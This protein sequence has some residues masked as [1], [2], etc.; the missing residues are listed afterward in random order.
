M[1]SIG[2]MQPYFFPYIGYYQLVNAVDTM[3]FYDDVQFIK[4]GW[5]NRNKILINNSA[6][7]ITVPC[8]SASQN[9]LINEIDHNLEK[10]VETKLLRK[11]ELAYTKATYFDR[12]FPIIEDVFRNKGEKISDISI[13]SIVS[14][15]KYLG[16]EKSFKVSSKSYDN[17]SLERADR[18][19][20]ITKSENAP[21]YINSIGGQE[22]YSK[23]Y[24]KEKGIE[25]KFLLPD[26]IK[27]EQYDS[28]FVPNLSMI[29]IIMFNAPEK[30][31]DFLNQYQL[32]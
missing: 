10:K 30:V 19:I 16:I 24:F 2:V 28:D 31:R 13:Q 6:N 9:K 32:V 18:L 15:F 1:S 7:Y 5:I 25:L 12:V 21:T 23:E 4:R 27:Y 22:L 11:I 20:D 3:V 8:K 14:I 26:S 17:E 29:D